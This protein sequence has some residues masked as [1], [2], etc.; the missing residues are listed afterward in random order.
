MSGNYYGPDNGVIPYPA[1]GIVVAQYLSINLGAL[2][3]Q[4]IGVKGVK[5]ENFTFPRLDLNYVGITGGAAIPEPST[6]G[7]ILGGLALAGAAIRRRS[8]K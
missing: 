3:T 8:K 6:Y 4:S 2:D 5:F 1:D 7:M